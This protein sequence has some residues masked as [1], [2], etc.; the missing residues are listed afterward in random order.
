M[1]SI[2]EV[3][4]GSPPLF[5]SGSNARS[6]GWL[7]QTPPPSLT[8]CWSSG[9]F[10]RV[11]TSFSACACVKSDSFLHPFMYSLSSLKWML[12]L[13]F[14]NLCKSERWKNRFSDAIWCIKMLN[15]IILIILLQIRQNTYEPLC[16][17]LILQVKILELNGAHDLIGKHIHWFWGRSN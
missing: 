13:T 17:K 1:Q 11:F 9:T 10:G 14:L 4:V 7:A 8:C 3:S 12:K 16:K 15:F 2:V 5:S 6:V